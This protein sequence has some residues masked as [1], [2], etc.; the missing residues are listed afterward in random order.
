[1]RFDGGAVDQNLRGQSVGSCE[2]VEHIRPDALFRPPVDFRA[3]LTR[4]AKN[5]H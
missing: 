1:M 4:E 3:E 2:R 5:F